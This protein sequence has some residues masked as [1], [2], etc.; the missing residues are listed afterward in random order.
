LP[1]KQAAL[2]EIPE[3]ERTAEQQAARLFG[4]SVENT[5]MKLT[6]VPA[7]EGLVPSSNQRDAYVMRDLEASRA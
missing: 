4:E 5:T 1:D 6:I 7:P 3:D 2:A